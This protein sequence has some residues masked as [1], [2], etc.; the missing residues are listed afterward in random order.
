MT[1]HCH[2]IAAIADCSFQTSLNG[3]HLLFHL[4][5]ECFLE[6]IGGFYILTDTWNG[7]AIERKI[8]SGC[9][10]DIHLK[11]AFCRL[12]ENFGAGG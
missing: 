7:K 5:E 1:D 11:N 10:R 9:A 8:N 6:A 3:E 4:E 12:A 2:D